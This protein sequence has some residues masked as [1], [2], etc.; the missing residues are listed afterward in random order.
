MGI[1]KNIKRMFSKNIDCADK[2][3][4]KLFYFYT[5]KN[6]TVTIGANIIVPEGYN[7]VFVCKD[8]VTDI[9]PKGKFAISGIN[10]PKTFKRMGLAKASKKGVLKKNFPA[11]IYYMA[12]NDAEGVRFSSYS[13]YKAKCTRLGKVKAHSEGTFSV[14]I[15]EPDKLLDFMLL[16]RA[17]ITEELFLDLLGGIVGDYVNKT[18]ESSDKTFYDLIT[19]PDMCNDYINKELS[20][21]NYFDDLGM[22]VSNIKIEFMKVSSK[23]KEKVQEEMKNQ[24]SFMIEVN[25]NFGTEIEVPKPNINKDPVLQEIKVEKNNDLVQ[26]LGYKTCPNCGKKINHS[27]LFCERCGIDLSK[28]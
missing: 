28:F 24:K 15:K 27:A 17:Y 3:E 4:N 9:V 6:R 26:E 2:L 8:K 21:Y 11:D 22:E 23:L 5:F 16:E 19:N 14:K 13:P 10:L 20:L 25:S 18:L 12:V 1:I 7:A